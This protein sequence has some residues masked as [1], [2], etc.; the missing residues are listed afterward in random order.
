MIKIINRLVAQTN[1]K[2]ICAINKDNFGS[3]LSKLTIKFILN[4]KTSWL[5]GYAVVCW[6]APY[7]S[8]VFIG[9]DRGYRITELVL[10][11]SIIL[12]EHTIVTIIDRSFR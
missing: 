12:L 4:L 10:L 7:F 5:E 6:F 3:C 11:P 2:N 9:A 8:T 1:K